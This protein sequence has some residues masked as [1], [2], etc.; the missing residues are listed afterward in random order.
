[1]TTYFLAFALEGFLGAGVSDGAL[2]P[3]VSTFSVAA[4]VQDGKLE[5][6]ANAIA[7]EAKR[8]REYGFSTSELNRAKQWMA[9]FY[10]RAYHERDKT[11]SG[12][13]AQ[14]CLN[15]FLED[16]PTPGIAY[17][18]AL[19]Q[20]V[21]PGIA[22]S[23]TSAMAQSLLADASRVILAVSPQ[24]PDIRIPTDVELQAAL[25]SAERTAVTAWNDTTMTRELM[26]RKPAPA[27]IESRR[28][29]ESLGVTI[30][31]FANGVEAWLKPTDFKNDQ[32]LFIMDALGGTSL[33]PPADFLQASLASTYV[34]LSGTGGLKAVDLQKVLT[35]KLASASPFISLSTHGISGSAAPAQLETALQLLYEKFTAPGDDPD[36]LTMMKRQLQ[37]RVAN[38]DQAPGQVFGERL[39][40]VNTS[41]HFTAQPLTPDRV[42]ALDREKMSGFYHA[43]FSN[44]A[45]FTFFMVGA[46]KLEDAIPL[47]A[48][49]VGSLPSTGRSASQ[50]KDLA[51]HFPESVQRVRVEA[52]VA[53]RHGLRAAT[54]VL[55]IALRDILRENL[56]QTYTVSVG[57]AQELPQR[58]NGHVEVSFGAAP[59]NVQA[60]TDRVLQEIKR[61][62]QE[63]P[64]A[65]LTNRAK[66]AARRNYETA[67]KQNGYWLR[68]LDSVHLLG[69]DPAD[70]LRRND[71]IDAVTPQALQDVFK[72]YFPFDR[73]TIVTLVPAQSAP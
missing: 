51:I 65:D 23:D 16:E 5:D 46:F 69:T 66:E 49:Y 70:I 54:T 43:R 14:E 35:G 8:V 20:Q 28:A 55:D 36:A 37:A 25:A 68:R 58:G 61:L 59:E 32:V 4:G 42:A 7:V 24:K 44:A 30:V 56:G 60:M 53:A 67:L 72:R 13:F 2:S 52:L 31:G 19:V 39:Q 18:Y 48:Q 34:E 17:E 41:N 33:A 45:D 73:S 6:G 29:L 10:E 9:A 40:Q 47:L 27:A 21:L 15:Y 50:F 11:E 1:M 3:D 64:S 71:R 63:G 62:Q 22:A 57:L 38:R 26:E 12:S